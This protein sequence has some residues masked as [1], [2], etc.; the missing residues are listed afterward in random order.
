[1][2]F[3]F[4]RAGRAAMGK[5]SAAYAAETTKSTNS[6]V[7]MCQYEHFITRWVEWFYPIAL[8]SR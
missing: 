3:I 5:L 2:D 7:A 8:L 1:M 4:N 6:L